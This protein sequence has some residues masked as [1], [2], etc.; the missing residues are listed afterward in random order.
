MS[1]KILAAQVD[2][3]VD[4]KK[5][6]IK[7]KGK[8]KEMEKIKYKRTEADILRARSFGRESL[9]GM[10]PTWIALQNYISIDQL[11]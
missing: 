10:N 5:I 6:F 8:K 1:H 4:R 11:E 3:E 9:P 2:E 7:P